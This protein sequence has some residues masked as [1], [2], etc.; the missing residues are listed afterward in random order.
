LGSLEAIDRWMLSRLQLHVKRATEAM[1]KMAVRKAIHSVL[2]ELT[3]DYQWYQ[4]RTDGQKGKRKDAVAYVLG[5]VLDAQVRMLTPVAPHICEEM[6]EMKGE[7]CLVSDSSWPEPDESRVDV[8]SEQ[9]EALIMEV[10]NDTWN[11]VKATKLAPRKIHYYLAAPWKWTIHLKIARDSVEAIV[12]KA[13]LMK[14]LMGMITMRKKAREVTRF[15]DQ[16]LDDVNRLPA[17]KKERVLE[18][19]RIVE[20]E[21]LKETVGFLGKELGA[22]IHVYSEEDAGLSDP[23]GR[24]RMAKPYRPAIFIE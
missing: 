17:D 1:D 23:N 24:S 20:D 2:Y 8:K 5:E 21:V 3:Q 7:K 12:Q 13:D 11:I 14:E 22:E 15:V 19:G 18:A 4:R 10:L 9:A 16:I 6:W